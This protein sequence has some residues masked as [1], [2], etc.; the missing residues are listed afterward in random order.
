MVIRTYSPLSDTCLLTLRRNALL[1]FL[2]KNEKTSG[3]DTVRSLPRANQLAYK[4]LPG[5]MMSQ[6][7]QKSARHRRDNLIFGGSK[8]IRNFG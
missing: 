1:P 2:P 8:E 7:I 6:S 5:Y 4:H 3:S